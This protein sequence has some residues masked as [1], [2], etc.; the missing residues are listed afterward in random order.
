[1]PTRDFDVNRLATYLH[2]TPQQVTRL[3]E[4]GKLPGRKVSGEWRFARAEIHNWLE[5]RIGL[6]DEEELVQMENALQ[7]SAPEAE[8][9]DISIAEL[10]PLEAIAAPLPARTRNSVITSMVDLAA[11]TGMLWDPEKM[12]DAVRS[13]EEM[14]PT[15]LENGVALLHARRPLPTILAQPFLAL[16][17]TSTPIPFGAG[18]PMTDV[19]F[20]ICSVEDRTHLRVLARLSRLL[21]VPGLLH[22]LRAAADSASARQLILDGEGQLNRVS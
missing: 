12:A 5:E 2:L 10:L 7:R 21:N 11:A 18:V 3:V 6:S 16:G 13:R 22:S 4:R 19:F 17:I 9:G 20:L 15:A 8:R 1:M 14:S